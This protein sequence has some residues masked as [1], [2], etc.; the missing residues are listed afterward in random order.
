MKYAALAALLLAAPAQ[1]DLA[2]LLN[3][4][5]SGTI[6]EREAA[7]EMLIALGIPALPALRAAAARSD[8]EVRARLGAAIHVLEIRSRL[9]AEVL[10]EFPDADRRIARGTLTWDGLVTMGGR[11]CDESP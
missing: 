6:E 10:D 2:P 3:T 11:S 5:G 1:D 4:L 9:P 7:E 8:G